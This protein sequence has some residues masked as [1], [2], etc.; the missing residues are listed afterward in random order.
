LHGN[1]I[2]VEYAAKEKR[3]IARYASKHPT[4]RELEILHVLWETGPAGL[5]TIC[6]AVR[7]HRPVATT[8]VATIL[9][10]M[11]DKKLVERTSG[12]RGYL[13]S[14]AVTRD[15]AARGMIGKL[16]DRV[17]DGSARRLVAHLI[18]EGQLDEHDLGELKRTLTSESSKNKP[19]R[20]RGKA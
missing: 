12:Q 13:W 16:V 9:Q 5:S 14:A 6:T 20:K 1:S 8:T 11:L 19:P 4:D 10:V 3:P 7:Q 18:E 17:F 15:T 2:S